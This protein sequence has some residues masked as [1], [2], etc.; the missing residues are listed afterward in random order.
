MWSKGLG[1]QISTFPEWVH[2]M[3]V[4]TP[5]AHFQS[6]CVLCALTCTFQYAPYVLSLYE[7]GEWLPAMITTSYSRSQAVLLRCQL[8]QVC[9]KLYSLHSVLHY[10]GSLVFLCVYYRLSANVITYIVSNNIAMIHTIT[11]KR[12]LYIPVVHYCPR[13]SCLLTCSKFAGAWYI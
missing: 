8:M 1:L 4:H 5:H 9:A 3:L 7:G 10:V 6:K 11:V 13:I 2:M 12:R